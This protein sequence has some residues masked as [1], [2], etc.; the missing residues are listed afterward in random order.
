M[1]TTRRRNHTPTAPAGDAPDVPGQGRVFLSDRGNRRIRYDD[2]D[3][4]R[5][6]AQAQQERRALDANGAWVVGRWVVDAQGVVSL[7]A[8]RLEPGWWVDDAAPLTSNLRTFARWRT[9]QGARQWHRRHRRPGCRLV[10][11]ERLLPRTH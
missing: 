8:V 6:R 11:L 2:V 5:A 10:N 3:T 1:L 9:R 7:E 4:I